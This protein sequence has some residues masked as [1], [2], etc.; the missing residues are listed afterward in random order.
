MAVTSA[1]ECNDTD[2]R[3]VDGLTN[4]DGRVEVCFN[5]VWGSVCDDDWDARD[6]KVVCRQL[7]IEGCK[8]SFSEYFLLILLLQ[9][10]LPIKNIMFC[11][12]YHLDDVRGIGYENKLSEC[13]HSGVG[14][15]D[16]ATRSE[17]AGVVCNGWF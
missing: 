13:G 9:H 14:V 7:G 11:L 6:A 5:R 2:V 3:L 17:E 12:F 16:C 10:Q 4:E 1:H 15:H 8:P